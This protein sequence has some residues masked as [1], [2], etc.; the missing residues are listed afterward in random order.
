MSWATHELENYVLQKHLKTSVSFLAVALG[1]FAPDLITKGFVYGIDFGVVKL[2]GHDPIAFHR[3]WPGAGFT[4]S[5][6]FGVVVAAL[7]LRFTG[8]RPWA[9]GLLIGHWAHVI[10]DINDTAGT[11]LFFPF[12]MENV[13]TGMWKHAAY[14]GRYGD[15]VAYYSSPGGVWDTFWL[16]IV[17]LFARG[18]LTRDYFRRVVRPTDSRVWGWLE[19][20]L[21]I[22]ERGL[23]AL[24]RGLLFY[25]GCR[26]AAWT[27]H[28]RFIERA[29][30]DP[31]WGGPH[32]IEHVDLSPSSLGQAL[33]SCAIGLLGLG[34]TLLLA[35]H[36]VLRRWWER[37]G[38]GGTGP[39][40]EPVALR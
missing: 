36:L 30:W 25:G 2:G 1:A 14:T 24:Y 15:A 20:R 21:H 26:I 28:A 3:D 29:E 35:W 6:L 40:P 33:L 38:D 39:S 9:L 5:L 8:S 4:H 16:A 11:M 31:S 19:R 37:A 7:V 22:G 18:T 12:S 34:L 13:T 32:W 23:L 10:T 17:L 27:I